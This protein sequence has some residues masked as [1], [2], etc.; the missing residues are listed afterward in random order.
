MSPEN[1]V[2]NIVT[3]IEQPATVRTPQLDGN[4]GGSFGTDDVVYLTALQTDKSFAFDY[5]IS[6]PD[7]RWTDLQGL[8]SGTDIQL[9]GCYPVP[10]G[11]DG[12]EFSF[13]IVNSHHKDLLLASPVT[14]AWGTASPVRLTFRHAMH[15]LRIRYKSGDS[16]YTPEE[17][18]SINT[19]I[20][21]CTTCRVDLRKGQLVEGSAT[22][23]ALFEGRGD[24]ETL[25][26]PQDKSS[27]S[28]TVVIDGKE[29]A[30]EWPATLS[31]KQTPFSR[32]ESG[33][34]LTMTIDCR[35]E[36]ME[37]PIVSI[38]GSDISGWEDQGT[39]DGS[40]TVPEE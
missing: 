35:K 33:K 27:A 2:L 40:V 14:A 19:K 4:G 25:L 31:D 15:K 3:C 26:V 34:V 22:G 20:T 13:N 1:A 32:F 21:A 16:S 39:I 8:D 29:I 28:L 36:V 30:C 7:I 5:S 37:G 12:N 17:L 11:V 10:E 23:S 38:D 6:T 18:Q 24:M 9:T